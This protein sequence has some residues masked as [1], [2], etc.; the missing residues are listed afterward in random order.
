MAE[1]KR[2]GAYYEAEKYDE[3]KNQI[4]KYVMIKLKTCSTAIGIAGRSD[5]SQPLQIYRYLLVNVRGLKN[6]V[7]NMRGTALYSNTCF[8]FNLVC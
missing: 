3:I 5:T 1:A 8:V 2:L 4:Y 6:A 7:C